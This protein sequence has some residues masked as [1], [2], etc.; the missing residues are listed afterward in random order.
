MANNNFLSTRSKLSAPS[1][2]LKIT[3][4]NSPVLKPAPRPTYRPSYQCSLSL[5]TVIGTTTSNRNGFSC[6]EPSRSFALCAGSAAILAEVDQDLNITQRFFRARPG[7]A[8]VNST[9]SYYNTSVAPSTPDSRTR[10]LHPVARGASNNSLLSASPSGELGDSTPSRIWGSRERVKAITSVS[11]SPNG[12]FLA[13]GEVCS[14][15][16]VTRQENNPC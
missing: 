15:C 5:Q 12:R 1:G 10:T 6:H 11:L 13:M 9:P 14:F 16:R 7:A 4:A 8:A 2:P 3:P